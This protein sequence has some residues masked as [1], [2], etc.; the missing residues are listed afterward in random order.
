MFTSPYP[1]EVIPKLSVFD[2]LFTEDVFQEF[3]YV[4]EPVAPDEAPGEV[5]PVDSVALSEF[6]LDEVCAPHYALPVLMDTNY[7]RFDPLT[8][9]DVLDQALY[10]NSYK[11]LLAWV[12]SLVQSDEGGA[13]DGD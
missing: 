13:A 5:T 7:F 2:F 9:P 11:D 6:M 4:E 3:I 8:R 12:G 1:D 10:R